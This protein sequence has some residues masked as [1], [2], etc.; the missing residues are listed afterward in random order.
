MT[1]QELRD[2]LYAIT[3]HIEETMQ[4][5]AAMEAALVE[6]EAL[7]VGEVGEYLADYPKHLAD[8]RALIARL[9]F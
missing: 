6:R 4:Y 1:D 7:A 3:K 5:V 2:A 9:H 8:V